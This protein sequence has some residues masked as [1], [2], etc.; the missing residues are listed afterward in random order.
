LA[1][2]RECPGRPSSSLSSS[3]LKKRQRAGSSL[4][5]GPT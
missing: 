3:S 1:L 5:A 4:V 2:V